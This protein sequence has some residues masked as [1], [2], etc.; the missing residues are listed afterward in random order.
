MDVIQPLAL[1][2]ARAGISSSTWAAR[3]AIEDYGTDPAKVH[4]V[5]F[6]PNLDDPP[7]PEVAPAR[8]P[9]P[10]CRLLSLP[11]EWARKGATTAFKTLLK[12]KSQ[13]IEDELLGA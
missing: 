3:S 10:P 6:G 4:V 5:P 8:Q 12:L 11:A 7:T 1:N 13:P 2:K 9:R